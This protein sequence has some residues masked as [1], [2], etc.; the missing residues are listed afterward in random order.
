MVGVWR[1]GVARGCR[2]TP[3]GGRKM[4]IV[5]GEVN[6]PAP[7]L[8]ARIGCPFRSATDHRGGVRRC[9]EE[10]PGDG[11]IPD[12]EKGSSCISLHMM[13]G[14]ALAGR[15]VALHLCIVTP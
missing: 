9:M 11:M 14:R 7:R 8:R 13:I 15:S 6:R 5:R 10:G 2:K 1:Q 3:R 4:R 12:P